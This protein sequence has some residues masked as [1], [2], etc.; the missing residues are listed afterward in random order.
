MKCTKCGKEYPDSNK[1]CPQCGEANP[2]TPIQVPPAS[3]QTPAEPVQPLESPEPSAKQPGGEESFVL[4]LKEKCTL[5]VLL[6]GIGAVV[7]VVGIIV[8]VVL[9]T[10]PNY[11]KTIT[12]GDKTARDITV[13]NLK[14]DRSSDQLEENVPYRLTGE[15]TA[16]W[17]GNA[18]IR[19]SLDTSQGKET[20]EVKVTLERKKPVEINEEVTAKGKV[21]NAEILGIDYDGKMRA[22]DFVSI[23]NLNSN[24]MLTLPLGQNTVTGTVKEDCEITCKGQSVQVGEDKRFSL[25]ENVTSG[26]KSLDFEVKDNEGNRCTMALGIEIQYPQVEY[27]GVKYEITGV[28]FKDNSRTDV[29]VIANIINLTDETKTVDGLPP[30]LL[31]PSIKMK[32]TGEVEGG[33]YWMAKQYSSAWG[34]TDIYDVM[35]LSPKERFDGATASYPFSG[36]ANRDPSDFVL[37]LYGYQPSYPYPYVLI[38]EFDLTQF[39][40]E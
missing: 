8:A 1:F 11:P 39:R 14:I 32:S 23:D 30:T 4:K 31:F 36:V 28:N 17:S 19:V 25:T 35:D 29:V 13:K 6:I 10:A 3:L 37:Q 34:E 21:K 22:E 24:N 33:G 40:T 38:A 9:L 12:L 7:V 27:Q 5:K 2:E 20:R 26:T 18:V 16:K 15:A